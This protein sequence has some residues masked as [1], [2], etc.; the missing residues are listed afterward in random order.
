MKIVEFADSVDPDELGHTVLPRL[1]LHC[2]PASL[3]IL[4]MI[5]LGQNIL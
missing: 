2:L 1:D 4:S 5:W 3:L